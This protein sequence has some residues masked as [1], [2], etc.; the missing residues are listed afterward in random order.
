MRTEDRVRREHDAIALRGFR[1]GQRILNLGKHAQTNMPS[2]GSANSSS[3]ICSKVRATLSGA[4]RR[5][6]NGGAISGG[7]G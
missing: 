6:F 2:P 4:S 3:P 7:T 5:M 1:E